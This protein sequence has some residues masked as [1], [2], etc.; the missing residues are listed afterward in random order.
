MKTIRYFSGEQ[1]GLVL[2]SV[3]LVF[4]VVSIL[5]ISLIDRQY[6]NIRRTE[7]LLAQDQAYV[8]TISA[9]ALAIR[10]LYEDEL[11]DN[12]QFG[13]LVDG[14]QDAWRKPVYFPLERGGIV[15][16][17][18]D[19]QSR[20]NVNNIQPDLHDTRARL[21]KLIT[22]LD[23]QADA[24]MIVDSL[25]QWMDADNIPQ[26]IGAEEDYYLGLEPAYRTAN[27]GMMHV[28]ELRLIRGMT[29]NLYQKLLP[30]VSVLPA[31]S[32]INVNTAT[33]EVLEQYMTP[34]TARVLIDR[35]ESTAFS[36]LEAAFQNQTSPVDSAAFSVESQFFLLNTKVTIED[37]TVE[38]ASLIY[39]PKQIT[40]ED[41]I[42]V[43]Q[44]DRAYHFMLGTPAT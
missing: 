19:L 22:Q 37:R 26:G 40:A 44:R 2:L 12:K 38:S 39:R 33:L 36:S 1:S 32:L 25:I 42:R 24:E 41:T 43:I 30:Y 18:T 20:L 23:S 11:Q 28:S 16:Q 21:K 3:M 5:V 27:H 31:G 35:R 15:A 9:E 8:Y 29:H 4:A 13:H 17:L 10:A 34:E 7:H 6:L 14:L